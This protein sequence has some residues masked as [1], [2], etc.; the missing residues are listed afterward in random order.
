MKANKSASL[1]WIDQHKDC[2][3]QHKVRQCPGN[4]IPQTGR[5]PTWYRRHRSSWRDSRAAA[6]AI[7][8]F[9]RHWGA[10][11]RAEDRHTLLYHPIRNLFR[12]EIVLPCSFQI[13]P[14]QARLCDPAMAK[15]AQNRARL[16]SPTGIRRSRCARQP[17]NNTPFPT[18]R[19][20]GLRF[21]PIPDTQMDAV[22]R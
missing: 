11:R 17:Y 2:C 4:V 1:K 3:W 21:L 12:L 19:V 22:N 20:G 7:R 14:R 9:I 6:R 18:N 15:A 5:D 16:A 10:A 13:E 8:G